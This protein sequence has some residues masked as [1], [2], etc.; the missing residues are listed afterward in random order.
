M[1]ISYNPRIVTDGL[2]LALDAGNTKSYPGSGTTWTDLSGNGNNGTLINMDGP[3]LDSANGGSFTFDGINEYISISNLGLSDHTI[4]GWINSS[5]GSQGGAD[6]NTIISIIG[7]YSAVGTAKYTYIGVLGNN[8]LTFRMDDGNISHRVIADVTYTDNQW[9][10][11][12]ITY[13]SNGTTIAYLNGEQL[14]SR[15]YTP[16]VVFNNTPF[17]VSR[18]ENGKYFNGLVPIVRSYNRALTASEIQQNFNATRSRFG[19]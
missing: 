16:N 14:Q 5:D 19:I 12:A 4:E 9:Y 3:N 2:V 13:N 1:A 17:N 18:A 11:T 7:T 6:G 8:V 15:S 10:H